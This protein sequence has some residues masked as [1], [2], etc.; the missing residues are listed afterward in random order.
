MGD[1]AIILHPM[2]ISDVYRKWKI[3]RWWPLPVTQAVTRALPPFKLSEIRGLRS[4]HAEVTGWFIA[5]PLTSSQM[6]Q[7]PP[8]RVIKK[9]AQAGRLAEKIGAKL[10]GLGA[11]AALVGDA[12]VSIA[13]SLDIAVTTGNSYTVATALEA[14]GKAAL[15]MGLDFNQAEVLVVGASDSIGSVCARMLARHVRFLTLLAGGRRKLDSLAQKILQ[16]NGL[17]VKITTD[18]RRAVQ[19][20]DVIITV[21]RSA[22][23]FIE[24]SDLKP[25]AV[26][27][28][29]IR[30]RD[31]SRRAAELRNDILVIEG[32]LVEMPGQA[33]LGFDFGLPP[34]TVSAG[35]AEAMILALEDKI[36]SYSLGHGLSVAQVDEISRLAGKHGF[37][38]VGFRCFDRAVTPEQIAVVRR[39]AI[40]NPALLKKTLSRL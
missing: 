39:N 17:A 5:C 25:G 18:V 40:R 19:R 28:D 21:T 24:V 29:V 8:E 10:V 23:G 2:E 1:F 7:L 31:F 30:P 34:G 15:A 37:R 20:A 12:G 11:M 4:P 3:L 22:E 33:N 38:V 13:K 16:E 14:A 9:I 6:I 35:M 26:V 36:E 32:G 27:C